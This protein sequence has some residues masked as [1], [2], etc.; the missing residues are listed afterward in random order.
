MLR[1]QRIENNTYGYCEETQEP[2]SIKRLDVRPIATLT[3][4]AQGIGTSA[5]KKNP[6]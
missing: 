6:P 1:I 5:T 2:I 3:I 4:E